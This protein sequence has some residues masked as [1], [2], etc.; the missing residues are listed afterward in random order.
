MLSLILSALLSVFFTCPVGGI[1]EQEMYYTPGAGTSWT[2]SNPQ[3]LKLVKIQDKGCASP[4]PGCLASKV[5]VFE[6]VQVGDE[7]L[8]FGLVRTGKV[9]EHKF[10]SVHV[11]EKK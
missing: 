9:V 8:D 11:T 3:K 1:F 10:V 2:V 6:A 5:F 7:L 4:K